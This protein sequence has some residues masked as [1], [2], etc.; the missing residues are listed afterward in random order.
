MI[1]NVIFDL[2]GVVIDLQRENAVEALSKLGIKDAEELLGEYSQK[3]PFLKLETGEMT[4]AEFYD[5]MLEKCEGSVSC[6]QIR[7]AFEKFLVEIPWE[8]LKM[9]E[10]LKAKGYRIF[11]LSNTNPIMFN[12]WIDRNFKKDGKTINDYFEGIVASFEEGVCKP[13]PV[14]FKNLIERYG[15]NPEETLMLDD[16]EK[17]VMAAESVGLK[18]VK[19]EPEGKN[20]FKSVCASLLEEA[21][22]EQ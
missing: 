8:R 14:I 2:G 3:G 5:L 11:A 12:H 22:S 19:I 1:K 20:S 17:N 21:P 15:L 6:I 9:L 13:D 7:D 16:S 18:A 4:S 10:S